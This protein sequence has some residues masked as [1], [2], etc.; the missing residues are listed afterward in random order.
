MPDNR[1]VGIA[2]AGAH[3]LVIFAESIVQHPMQVVLYA[4]MRPHDLPQAFRV[5]GIQAADEVTG[6]LGGFVPAFADGGDSNDAG[7]LRPMRMV[8]R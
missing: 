1:H 8:F 6:F 7:E 3:P 5:G 2:V 4:P